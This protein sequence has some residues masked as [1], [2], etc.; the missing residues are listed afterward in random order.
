VKTDR[1][2]SGN[3]LDVICGEARELAGMNIKPGKS[4]NVCRD[5][6][7]DISSSVTPSWVEWIERSEQQ[8]IDA[9]FAPGYR[10]PP[11]WNQSEVLKKKP[12]S[13]W[14]NWP[15]STQV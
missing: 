12:W 13:I 6:S 11:S 14:D 15:L 9:D 4:S 8:A 3:P 2:A 5:T 10:L 7:L 1:D